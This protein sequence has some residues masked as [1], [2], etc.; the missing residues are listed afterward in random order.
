MLRFAS[1]LLPAAL[2][3]TLAGCDGSSTAAPA[4]GPRPPA[5]AH[6]VPA[7][8]AQASLEPTPAAEPTPTPTPEPTP[9]PTPQRTS[10]GHADLDPNNDHEV[11]PPEPLDDCEARLTAAGVSF[12]PARI[13]VS[14][15]V[16]GVYTCGA[17]QVVR[18]TRGPGDI[19]YSSSPLMT[20]TM[21]LALAD[22]ERVAQQQA[23]QII[24]SRITSIDHMGT[25]N[26][27][28]MVNFNMISE[29]SFANAFDI[30]A[31]NFKNGKS[32]SV[33]GDFKP[34]VDQPTDPKT[35]FLRSLANRLYDE[36]VYSTVLTPYFDRLHHN[37][38][39]FDLA[40]YRVDGSRP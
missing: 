34:A 2:A 22:F 29:H 27:R 17:H 26:C 18:V 24:G 20:C 15:K 14:N 12:K 13:G 21:A 5:P 35:I 4:N 28:K 16:N 9:E 33:L 8:A 11:G 25:Y 38:F 23:E 39:H 3:L 19:K 31:F 30:K 32:A 40:R 37:H 36:E 7:D 10:W 1:V 6:P